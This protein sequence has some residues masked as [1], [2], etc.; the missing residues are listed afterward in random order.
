MRSFVSSMGGGNGVCSFIFSAASGDG[1][2][3]FL[4]SAG[5]GVGVRL[6]LFVDCRSTGTKRNY[7]VGS[8]VGVCSE[9][10]SSGSSGVS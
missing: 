4:F 2:H 8:S 5:G 9:S 10:S 6:V 1:V 7:S 3:S